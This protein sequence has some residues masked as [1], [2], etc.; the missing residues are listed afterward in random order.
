M[1]IKEQRELPL[2][3]IVVITYNSAKYVLETLESAYKQTYAGSLELIIADDCSTDN[4]V[5]VCE[6]WLKTK[7]ARFHRCELIKPAENVGV[8]KNIN[9]GCKAAHGIWIK[10][11]AGDDIL[12]DDCIEKMIAFSQK[13]PDASFIAA[14]V[15]KFDAASAC[16]YLN[17]NMLR[18]CPIPEGTIVNLAYDVAHGGVFMPSPGF[19]L[20]KNLLIDVG[21]FSEEIRNVEDLPTYWR[22]LGAGY[23]IYV[24]YEPSV[25][26]RVNHASL[27][28]SLSTE[29]GYQIC[30][31]R[32]ES[33]KNSCN[34]FVKIEFMLDLLEQ[35]IKMKGN[36]SFI[37]FVRGI[38]KL[39]RMYRLFF[40]F[41]Y[42][43]RYL[44]QSS[45]K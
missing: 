20:K 35:R 13:N 16:D 29:V 11:I 6:T 2:V 43:P 18:M 1:I 36:S 42:R 30:L 39:R 19:F 17:S 44:Q 4:T 21:F 40:R 34:I 41:A 23:S 45:I 24:A 9:R 7:S 12:M 27:S 10:P 25:Y 28:G 8:S 26:Y 22:I 38:G 14:P 31:S 15:I 5:D 3:S 32:I 37:A 33:L